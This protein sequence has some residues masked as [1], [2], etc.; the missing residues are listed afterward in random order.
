M[1]CRRQHSPPWRRHLPSA[2]WWPNFSPVSA[3]IVKQRLTLAIIA[4]YCS[5]HHKIE[6]CSVIYSRASV[7]K[8][9]RKLFAKIIDVGAWSIEAIYHFLKASPLRQILVAA[10]S[11]FLM[12]WHSWSLS[13]Y[14]CW[15]TIFMGEQHKWCYH[16][17][18]SSRRPCH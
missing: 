3:G 13:K 2:D 12:T 17:S 5:Y 1:R 4:N 10:R 14:F 6:D 7:A 8:K 15:H 18:L 11:F 16:F 9:S